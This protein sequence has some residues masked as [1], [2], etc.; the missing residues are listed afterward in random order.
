M[1]EGDSIRTQFVVPQFLDVETKIIGPITGRQFAIMLGTLLV[2]FIIYRIF[3]NI[4]AVISLGIPVLA[5]GII[6]SFVKVNGQ[7]FHYLILNIVQ[8]VRRPGLRVW[9]KTLSDAELK[10]R[11]KKEEELPPIEIPK[12]SSLRRSKLNEVALVVNTGGVYRPEGE[13]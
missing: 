8:T 11:I 2:E 12:K 5:I 1:P 10:E 6:F 7:P 9:D 3:L 4:F 13:L